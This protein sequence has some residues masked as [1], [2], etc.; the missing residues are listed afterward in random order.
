MSEIV[1]ANVL[2][3]AIGGVGWQTMYEATVEYSAQETVTLSFVPSD[4]NNGSYGPSTITLPPTG[5]NPTKFT[6]K[7]GANKWK[8]MAFQFTSTDPSFEIFLQGFA[9]QGKNWGDQSAFRPV[10]PFAPG[11][12]GFGGQG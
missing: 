9:I 6:F 8:F 10:N 7:V 11:G 4:M 5:G 12:G 3:P 2:T 1:S